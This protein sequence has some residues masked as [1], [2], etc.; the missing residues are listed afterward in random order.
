MEFFDMISDLFSF[1]SIFLIFSIFQLF[2]RLEKSIGSRLQIQF[3]FV[4]Y[5]AGVII[6][7]V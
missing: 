4:D 7:R 2:S 3:R 1:P 5:L 6:K